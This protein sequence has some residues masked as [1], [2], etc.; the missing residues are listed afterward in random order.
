MLAVELSDILKKYPNFEVVFTSHGEESVY[1]GAEN[2]DII[3]TSEQ[4]YIDVG[5][6]GENSVA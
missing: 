5:D 4:V 1:V 3:F 2:V 6:F